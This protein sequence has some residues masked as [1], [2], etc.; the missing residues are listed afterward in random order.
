MGDYLSTFVENLQEHV[1]NDA[2]EYMLKI[3]LQSNVIAPNAYFVRVALFLP[4][5]EVYD[6]LE[7]IC[8]FRIIDSGS[9]MAMFEGFNYGNFI[10]GYEII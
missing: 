8:P 9:K 10:L 3:K 6:I 1:L 5:G 2:G 7:M 4:M